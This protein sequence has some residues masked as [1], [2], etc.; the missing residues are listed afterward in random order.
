MKFSTKAEYGLRAIAHLDKAGDKPVS[1]AFIAKNEGL[2]LAYLERLFAQLKK[3]KLIKAEKGVKGGYLLTK[4]AD[5]ISV[6]QVIESLEGS[7]APY[8]CVTDRSCCDHECKVHPVWE[9][10]YK[11]ITK[12]LKDIKLSQ[13]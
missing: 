9:K 12:T 8:A 7:V 6:L 4:K 1:L 10:L 2:S 13:L 5:K 3:D 11:Q